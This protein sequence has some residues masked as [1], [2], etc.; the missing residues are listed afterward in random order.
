MKRIKIGILKKYNGL[1][2]IILALLGYSTACEPGTEE[3]GAPVAEYGVPHASFIVKGNVKSKKSDSSISNIRVVMNYDTSYTDDEGNYHVQN[4]DF[5]DSQSY[6][7]EFN[8][9]DGE[10][11]G[12]YQPLDTIIEFNNPEFSGSTD[13]WDRGETEKEVNVKLKD[14]E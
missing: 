13:K 6:H 12:A 7:M 14:K 3:Y 5:P 8:D 11:N 2:S 9:I 1:I 10:T 4:T